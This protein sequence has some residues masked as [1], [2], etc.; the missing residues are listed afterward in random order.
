MSGVGEG[1]ESFGLEDLLGHL[2]V[3]KA[4]TLLLCIQAHPGCGTQFLAV[5]P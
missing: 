4:Q 2:G 3:S 5:C 1:R